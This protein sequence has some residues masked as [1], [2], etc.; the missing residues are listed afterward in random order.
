M[1]GHI[2]PEAAVGGPI[3]ILREGDMVVIDIENRQLNVELSD[4]EIQTRLDAWQP[5]APAL[6]PPACSPSMRPRSAPP[7]R[8]R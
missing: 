4:A 1:A 6:H 3:A 8:A 7:P 2:A 5:P